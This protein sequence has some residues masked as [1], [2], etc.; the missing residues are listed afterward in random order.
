[1]KNNKYRVEVFL[2]NSQYMDPLM[3]FTVSSLEE[4]TIKNFDYFFLVSEVHN[5]EN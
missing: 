1:M 5:V 4:V 2:K 3:S